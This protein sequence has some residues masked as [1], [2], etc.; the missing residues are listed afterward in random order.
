M[1][2]SLKY[3]LVLLLAIASIGSAIAQ[4]V[5]AVGT[6]IVYNGDL[7]SARYR[8][9]QQAIKQAVLQS[10]SRVSVNDVLNN[11]ELNSDLKIRSSGRVQHAKIISETQ[12]GDFLTLVARIN[13]TADSMCSNGATNYYQKSVAITGFTLQDPQQANLGALGNIARELPKDLA[14]TINKQGFLRA[15]TAT[16]LSIYPDSVN[17]PSRTN[18]DGTITNV[19]RIGQKMGVQYVVS[20]IIRDIG[21]LYLRH[22]NDPYATVDDSTDKERN[23]VLDI[24]IYD[25]FSGALLFQKRYSEIGN[26]DISDQARVRFGSA[27][28]WTIH[29]GKVVRE[30]LRESAIDTSEK[31]RCQPFMATIFRTE[32]RRIHIAAG[33]LAGIKAGDKFNVY[34]RYEIFNQDQKAETQLNNANISVTIKQVQ[35]NFS[36]GEL[37]VDARI[38]NVQQQD[39]VI[40]W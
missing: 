11:G 26:W 6:A 38:L 20:G 25:G 1:K 12:K 28:F 4:T 31:L 14:D 22:P 29:Y 30:A 27:Q 40:A 16:D 36:I 10:S 8:A 17:A 34:R 7:E 21:P 37:S 24:Y 35:P 39:V 32:G 5:D 18:P 19:A 3:A 33:S 23:F 13:V 15:L 2:S 9:T